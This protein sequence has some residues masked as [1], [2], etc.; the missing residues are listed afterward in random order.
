MGDL[1]DDLLIGE[2]KPVRTVIQLPD[3]EMPVTSSAK[4]RKLREQRRMRKRQLGRPIPEAAFPS[5]EPS[6]DFIIKTRELKVFKSLYGDLNV[7][8]T[9]WDNQELGRWVADQK[10]RF[11]L[12][13]MTIEEKS[14]LEKT[15]FV[16]T[17]TIEDAE[18]HLMFHELRRFKAVFGNLKVPVRWKSKDWPAAFPRWFHQQRVLYQERRLSPDKVVKLRDIIGYDLSKVCSEEALDDEN[19]AS[20]YSESVSMYGSK[21]MMDFETMYKQLED[22]RE[23]YYTCHVPRRVYDSSVLGEWVHRIRRKHKRRII[24]Q[25]MI[26]RLNELDFEWK[27]HQLDARWYSLYHHVRRYKERFG[28]PDIPED[29][30]NLNEP[31]WVIASK[32]LV[33]QHKLY[34]K[35]KL[36]PHKVK[37]L[38]DLGI[39]LDRPYGPLKINPYIQEVDPVRYAKMRAK[40][41]ELVKKRKRAEKRALKEQ[42]LQRVKEMERQELLNWYLPFGDPRFR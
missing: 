39:K 28:T 23:R 38:K 14:L 37:L 8:K 42:K 17:K 31:N 3:P 13:W 36:S 24:E 2:G 10:S 9:L 22:W 16:W 33:R 7:P 20:V 34:F 5:G 40:H 21:P 19:Y 35:Q 30:E 32:W 6:P 29:Y 18:W 4:L 27:V 41:E 25:W 1:D 26:E 15:G 11:T 12:K